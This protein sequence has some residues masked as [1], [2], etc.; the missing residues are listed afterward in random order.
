MAQTRRV[1]LAKQLIHETR[2]PMAEVA[3]AA[4]FGSVRRFNETFQPLFGRPPGALRRIA[5]RTSR[6]ARGRRDRLRLRYQPPYD[7]PAML[8]FLAARAIAGRR[9]VSP[10]TATRA[11]SSSSGEQGLV[12]VEPG[13][14]DCAARRRC[15]FRGSR[16]CRRSSRACAGC[17]TSPPTRRRSPPISASDPALAPLVAARP[18]LR[19]PGA[20][21]GFELAI[22][23]MLGQQITVAAAARLAGRL[24]AAYGEPLDDR[25]TARA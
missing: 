20:W 1:L 18:G 3:F 15:A 12:T 9:G 10:P 6:P 7:W 13:A 22:R 23:A 25:A 5:G 21:D 24:V 11:P 17:S 14:G 2:L 4:G 19:V 16:P 8:G